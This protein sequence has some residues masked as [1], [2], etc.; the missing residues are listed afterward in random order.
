MSWS[1]PMT[2]VAGSILTAAQLNTYLSGNT[3]ALRS[4]EI[5]LASQAANDVIV[6][7]SAT[8]FGRLAKG[9]ALQALRVNAA[10]S[11]LEFAT[12]A[13]LAV[14][15]VSATTGAA[16][17]T[18]SSSLSDTG[19]TATITPTSTSNLVLVLVSQAGFRSF[20]V[21][22]GTSNST[23]GGDLRLL[24]NGSTIADILSAGGSAFPATIGYA[25]LDTPASIAALTYKT[26][27]STAAAPA[28][29]DRTAVQ[30]NSARSTIVLIEIAQ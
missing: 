29:N 19:L 30:S 26:Q 24:R 28:M 15:I 6:A 9:A 8:Q 13:G 22:S 12:L 10:G 23:V 11:G 17:S 21:S 25:Y 5:S 18:S 20:D 27:Y 3:G 16:A 4:G 2:F 14:Q 1:S 7:S